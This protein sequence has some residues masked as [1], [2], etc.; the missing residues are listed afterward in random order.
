MSVARA[1]GR[2]SIRLF[3]GTLT[4]KAL[5]FVLYLLLA[6]TLGVEQFGRYTFALSFTLLFNAL[7]D[8]GI[9]TVFTREVSR[10][11]ARV[12]ELL[13]PCLTVKLVLAVITMIAVLI[14]AGFG[15]GGRESLSLVVPIV[16][17]ML[18]NSAAMVFDGMLRAAGRAGRSGLNLTVQSIAALA[19]GAGLLGIGLGPSAGAYA[20]LAGAIVR[21]ISALAW[22]HDL[23]LGSAKRAAGASSALAA[24]A[25][26]ELPG[27]VDAVRIG[28]AAPEAVLGDSAAALAAR[29]FRSPAA[30]LREAVP[31]ALSGIFIALYFRIDAVILRTLQGDVAVGLYAGVY[32]MFEAFAILAVTFRS[33]LFPVMAR[34]ADGPDGSLGVLCRKSIRLH[35]LFTLGVAVFFTFQAPAIVR[36]VLGPDY[37]AAA[38]AL[39]I[40]I[41]ALP[42]SYMADSLLFMLTAQRRQSLGTWAVGITAVANV[43]LNLLLVPR[44]SFLGSAVATVAS[45][46]LSFALLFA[47]FQRAAPVRGL[48]AVVWRPVVAGAVLAAGLAATSSWGQPGI[49]G[50]AIAGISSMTAYALLLVVLGAIGREDLQL[51]KSLIPSAARRPEGAAS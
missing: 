47:M 42:G 27:G 36:V 49:A 20:F 35:L 1:V 40:L 13:R 12:R 6:R 48:G 17:G 25:P 15:P 34:A 28:A 32:R 10:D 45:E 46:C 33:V 26:A 37:A 24:R 3:A 8:L 31:L 39:A 14:A 44:I 9:S 18:L 2:Q 43:I 41:W 5:D 19:C 4:A 22:S 29:A 7:G 21:T 51:V 23:W 50:L 11:P 30:L 38:P 16:A